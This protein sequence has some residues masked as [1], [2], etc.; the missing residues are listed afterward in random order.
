MADTHSINRERAT[1]HEH[2]KHHEHPVID[3]HTRYRRKYNRLRIILVIII[4]LVMSLTGVI[5]KLGCSLK[6]QQNEIA[7]LSKDNY[8]LAVSYPTHSTTSRISDIDINIKISEDDIIILSK[9]VY[10][11]ARGVKPRTVGAKYITSTE[12]MA[13]CVWSVLNRV[14]AGYATTITEVVTAPNQYTG[15]S[16]NN[17]VKEEYAAL[18]KDVLIRWQFEKVLDELGISS[19]VGRTLPA[20]EG[21]HLWCWFL[22]DKN[23]TGNVFRSKY[24]NGV[25]YT[26]SLHSPYKENI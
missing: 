11:E 12:Q 16:P 17:P 13:A 15:Y 25:M 14:D 4:I 9:M 5:I 8:E 21:D 23:G 22:A 10:G 18:V 1:H 20:P 19:E 6:A 7:E 3:H 26:W 2:H 24:Q